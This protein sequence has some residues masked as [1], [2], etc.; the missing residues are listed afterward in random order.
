M[1][2]AVRARWSEWRQ[3]SEGCAPGLTSPWSKGPSHCCYKVP[4]A[5]TFASNPCPNLLRWSL[6]VELF[7]PFEHKDSQHY[8][9]KE[10]AGQQSCKGRECSPLFFVYAFAPRHISYQVRCL[11]CK[12]TCVHCGGPCHAI[13]PTCNNG[14]TLQSMGTMITSC[15][16]HS[17]QATTNI[18]IW[19]QRKS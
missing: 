11:A 13:A 1:G 10:C 12:G 17:V 5:R 9:E 15:C 3:I 16:S 19:G 6:K 4:S 7:L 8:M 18:T 14:T 2:G